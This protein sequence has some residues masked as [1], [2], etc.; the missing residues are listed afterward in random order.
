MEKSFKKFVAADGEVCYVRT[1]ETQAARVV[2]LL[3]SKGFTI[4]GFDIY[5]HGS[6]GVQKIDMNTA[7]A[8]LG[9]E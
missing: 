4:H 3:E 2:H 9:I 7:A 8:L 5:A 1:P 6:L